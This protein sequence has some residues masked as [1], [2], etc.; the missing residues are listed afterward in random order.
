MGADRDR[1][2]ERWG[3]RV[4]YRV[5]A[6]EHC[7]IRRLDTEV[8]GVSVFWN[9]GTINCDFVTRDADG[10]IA[11]NH[12]DHSDT[13]GCPCAV[14]FEN[15]AIPRVRPARSGTDGDLRL[16]TYVQS[17][18]RA[19]QITT[20]LREVS[21]S[22]EVIDYREI[23]AGEEWSARIDLS[24]L[25]DKQREAIRM[26]MVEGYYEM[27]SET[28]VEDLA[29]M[30]GISSSAFATRLRKAEREIFSQLLEHV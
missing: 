15:D 4:E 14:V 17:P 18:D 20:A 25:T 24:G 13:T 11:V 26:A 28:T 19:E 2:F 16:T 7:P 9:D 8:T 21:S 23:G 22:F 29:A 5:R 30:T 10:E 12:V 1:K 3:H 6:P 27:P